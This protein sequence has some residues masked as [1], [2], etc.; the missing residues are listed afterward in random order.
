MACDLILYYKIIIFWTGEGKAW[1]N[2]LTE[3]SISGN[4]GLGAFIRIDT[5]SQG[6]VFVSQLFFFCN[7]ILLSNSI[8]IYDFFYIIGDT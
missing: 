8:A 3:D 1:Q 6:D 5:L 4:V 7:F 2:M